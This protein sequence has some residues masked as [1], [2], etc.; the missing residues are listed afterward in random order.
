MLYYIV[1]YIYCIGYICFVV[2][3][4]YIY[5]YIVCVCQSSLEVAWVDILQRYGNNHTRLCDSQDKLFPLRARIFEVSNFFE[6][7]RVPSHPK[8]HFYNQYQKKK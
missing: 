1:Y 8:D 7:C 3:I 4:I 6:Q 2:Y 5:I